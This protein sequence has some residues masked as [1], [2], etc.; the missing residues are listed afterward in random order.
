M[1]LGLPYFRQPESRNAATLSS[2]QECG[3]KPNIGP[4]AL[5]E[6]ENQHGKGQYSL[7]C[8]SPIFG[9]GGIL[10]RPAVTIH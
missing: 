2:E 3:F 10:L 6:A 7:L 1:Q 8:V 4:E 5:G 9:G